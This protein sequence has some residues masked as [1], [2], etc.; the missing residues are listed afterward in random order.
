[1]TSHETIE[2]LLTDVNMELLDFYRTHDLEFQQPEKL[3]RLNERLYLLGG[4]SGDCKYILNKMQ[5][6]LII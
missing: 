5:C 4:S 2:V 3:S 6:R 1:M